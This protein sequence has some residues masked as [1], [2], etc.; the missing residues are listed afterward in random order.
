MGNGYS[1]NTLDATINTKIGTPV[2]TGGT[3]DLASILGNPSNVSIISR[4]RNKPLS[5]VSITT[6]ASN[7]TASVTCW[8]ITGSIYVHRLYGVVTTVL[9]SNHTAAHWRL[10]DGTNTPAVTLATGTTLSSATVGSVISKGGLAAAALTL[11]QADQARVFESATAGV[12]PFSP[13]VCLAKN[14]ATTTLVYRYTTTNTPATGAIQ[15]FMEWEPLSADG[16]V[17]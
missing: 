11:T 17:A 10:E 1:V 3:A 13:F 2:N 4:L 15:M 6:N 8:T 12:V 5:N 14:G 9:S 7:T 16:A